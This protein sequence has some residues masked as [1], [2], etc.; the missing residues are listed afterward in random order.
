M[1]KAELSYNPYLM[2]INVKFNGQPPHINSLIEKYQDIPLQDWIDVIPQI[3][4]DEMNGYFFELDYYGTALDC[5]EVIRAFRKAGVTEKEVPVFLKKELASRET[6]IKNIDELLDWLNNNPYR[7]FNV[8]EF[9]K[10]NYDL[11]DGNYSCVVMHGIS[12]K[13]ELPSISV[14]LVSNTSELDCVDLTHIPVIYCISEEV[15]PVLKSDIDYFS[16]RDDITEEQLFFS[17][18]AKLERMSIYRLLMDLGI[19]E[20]NIVKDINDENVQKYFLIYPFSDYISS[21]IK[22]FRTT[23]DELSCVLKNDNAAGEVKGDEIHKQLKVIDDSIER[24]RNADERILQHDNIEYPTEFKALV[25][26]FI[27]N[28]SNWESRKTKITDPD[29]ANKAAENLNAAAKRFFREYCANIKTTTLNIAD[30]IRQMYIEWYKSA[31]IEKSFTDNVKF[32]VETEKLNIND[33]IQGMLEI[34]EEKYVKVKNNRFFKSDDPNTEKTTVLV[35][36]YYLNKWRAYLLSL[37]VPIVEKIA[38]DQYDHL[39]NYLV[40]LTNVYHDQ[41]LALKSRQILLKTNVTMGLSNDERL[42][43]HDNDWLTAF[44]DQLKNIERS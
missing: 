4:H 3:F 16:E 18:D 7:R 19:T 26:E 30:S 43:Q 37:I 6:K 41:L 15:L 36:T 21:A 9:R 24:I 23:I 10:R 25:E 31:Q 34:K 28:I 17:I 5:N 39:K 32:T 22:T 20:P 8:D 2:E 1:I 27:D 11:F 33:N 44:S 12:V 29:E 14:D 13:S 42:L 40:E 38:S 35:T